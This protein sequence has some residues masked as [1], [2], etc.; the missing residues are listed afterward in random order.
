MS[1]LTQP[2]TQPGT[3]CPRFDLIWT[4]RDGWWARAVGWRGG[5]VDLATAFGPRCWTYDEFWD[6]VRDYGAF[7]RMF[8]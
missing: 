1:D 6:W 3:L 7:P 4:D 8:I 5:Y 2:L